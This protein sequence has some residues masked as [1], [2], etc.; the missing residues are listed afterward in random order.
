[1]NP[2]TLAVLLAGITTARER[3]KRFAHVVT[4]PICQSQLHDQRHTLIATARRRACAS[5][6]RSSSI[7]A[8]IW[9]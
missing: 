4:C 8:K 9:R 3:W 2:Y 7:F 6:G 5:L 1:M